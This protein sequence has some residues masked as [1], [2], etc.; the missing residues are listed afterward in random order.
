MACP[1]HFVCT[2]PLVYTVPWC[3]AKHYQSTFSGEAETRDVS[4]G[5]CSYRERSPPLCWP[6]WVWWRDHGEAIPV[7][8]PPSAHVRSLKQLACQGPAGS[9]SSAE[10]RLVSRMD[11]TLWGRRTDWVLRQMVPRPVLTSPEVPLPTRNVDLLSFRDIQPHF[12][13]Y[14]F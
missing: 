3:P 6:V 1:I 14:L 8:L 7:Y 5:P 9:L 12:F 4:S 2:P 10:V 11:S 13:V